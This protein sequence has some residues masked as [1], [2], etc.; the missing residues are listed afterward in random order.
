MA[1]SATDVQAA[2]DRV[3]SEE[4]FS[5]SASFYRWAL[6]V[7]DPQPDALV[8]DVA[9]G[10][11]GLLAAAAEAGAH[12]IGLDISPVAL[13]VARGV[14]P[15]AGL[16]TADAE[17]LPFADGSF[18]YLTCLGSLEHYAD[19]WRGLEEIR[20]V[21][22][23]EGRAVF[24]MPNSYYLADILYHVL[25]HGRGPTHH[26][27]IQRFATCQEWRT[28][29]EMMGLRVE[30]MLR[31]DF[32]FP[33]SRADWRWYRQ[34][35][36]KLL[37]LAMRPVTPF[38]LAYSYLYVCSAGAPRPELNLSLPMALRRPGDAE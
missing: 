2:Y 23:P 10:S 22:A 7:L 19:P 24:M 17:V 11:G 33:R 30:R 35:P 9:C 13:R 31:Y 32:F 1:V 37:Y 29:L 5:D 25:L 27:V 4:G 8:L 18:R 20:R 3:F 38:N 12:G 36:R 26:Q 6:R 34:N 16:L 28:L 21:L 15:G 14:A